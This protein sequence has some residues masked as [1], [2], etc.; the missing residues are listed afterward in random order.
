ML[1]FL[2][3]SHRPSPNYHTPT[4]TPH[5]SQPLRFFQTAPPIRTL[6]N[7]QPPQHSPAR[8]NLVTVGKKKAHKPTGTP[9]LR[10]ADAAGLKYTLI[11]YE[12]TDR[13]EGGYALDSARVLGRDPSSL[14]KTLLAEVDGR[15]VCALVP[16]SN[17]L[18]LKSLAKAAEGKRAEMM[19]PAKAERLTG[20]VTG[21]I[22]PLGQRHSF[23][24]FIDESALDH[25]N[26]VISG[27]KRTLS[28]EVSPEALA[29]SINAV[30]APLAD[31]HHTLTHH[32]RP[33]HE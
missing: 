8:R 20:Y 18:N 31:A 14:F 22:S 27:G 32:S 24:I 29:A 4:S 28:L 2:N 3:P 30:F 10:A 26:I 25:P 15:P 17:L 13:Q 11:E 5:L 9:A 23:P 16:A 33:P 6:P 7:Y 1:E 12:H 21:G 19:S